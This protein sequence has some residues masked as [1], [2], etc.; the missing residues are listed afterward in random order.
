MFKLSKLTVLIS[1][2]AVPFIAAQATEAAIEN[3]EAHFEQSHIT[4]DYLRKFDPSA[5]LTLNYEGVGDITPGQSLTI[6]RALSCSVSS[7]RK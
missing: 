3:I 1:L 6:P 4:E 2:I 5:L 7:G